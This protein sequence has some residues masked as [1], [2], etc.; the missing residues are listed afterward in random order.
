MK[1]LLDEHDLPYL[2]LECLLDWFLDPRRPLRASDERRELLFEAAAAL[3][4]HHIKVANIFGRPVRAPAPQEEF[5]ALCAE[6]AERH[7]ALMVYEFM[8]FDANVQD[9][10]TALAVVGDIPN[11]GIAI[12]TWHL[13]K[14]GI[15]ADGLR[16]IP[17]GESAGSSCPTACWRTCPTSS[18]RSSTTAGCPARASSRS[19]TTSPPARPGLRRT[20]GRRGPL[21]GAPQP[22]DRR[23]LRPKLRDRERQLAFGEEPPVA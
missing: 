10:E 15:E 23:D 18:T 11:A 21:R 12:D 13:G 8:P 3:D 6:A 16:A 19:A 22:A 17:A 9:V 1:A 2:E 7:D 14:L 4:A 5:A 20:V